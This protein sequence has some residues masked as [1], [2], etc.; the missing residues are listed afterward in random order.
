LD[1]DKEPG[2][3]T[4]SVIPVARFT[5]NLLVSGLEVSNLNRV[6]F[7]TRWRGPGARKNLEQQVE[8]K[9]RSGKLGQHIEIS[10]DS[11]CTSL[12]TEP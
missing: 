3:G 4:A 9:H 1:V 5:A 12:D 10:F 7:D 2:S 6:A 11:G 8:I